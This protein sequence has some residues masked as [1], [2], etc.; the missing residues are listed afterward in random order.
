MSVKNIDPKDAFKELNNK[1]SVL[2]DV[3]TKEELSNVGYA[4]LSLLNK[5]FIAIPWR[6][7]PDMSINEYFE[8]DLVDKLEEIYKEDKNI[9]L[10]FLCRSGARSM[11]AALFM[12][13]I[14]YNCFN[15]TGGF[16]GNPDNNGVRG[17]I[18]GWKFVQNPWKN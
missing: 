15:I 9:N 16:E 13:D 10:F 18:D 8:A 3:R 7:L 12:S 11:E 14:G 2:I 4:D 17:N 5:D 1:N 6:L